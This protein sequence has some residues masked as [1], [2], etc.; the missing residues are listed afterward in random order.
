M[1]ALILY[2]VTSLMLSNTPRAPQP[3]HSIISGDVSAAAV[4][5]ICIFGRPGAGKTSVAESAIAKLQQQSRSS[6]MLSR[7]TTFTIDPVGLDLDVCVPQWMKE[8]FAKGIY[9]TLAERRAF[10]KGCCDYVEE[11]MASA[12]ATRKKAQLRQASCPPS[13]RDCVPQP[14]AD[15][16]QQQQQSQVDGD[17][18]NNWNNTIIFAIVSFSFVNTD[19]RDYYRERFPHTQWV[20]IDTSES[21]ATIR[22]EQRKGHFY[23]GAVNSKTSFNNTDRIGIPQLPSALE[24]APT[25][26][27]TTARTTTTRESRH[28]NHD[29][30]NDDWKFAP[31]DF[32]HIVLD[33]TNSIGDNADQVVEIIRTMAQNHFFGSETKR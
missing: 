20:L 30:D 22:I 10:A 27:T 23:K 18:N 33:G 32:D 6:I 21:E 8:N 26:T 5:M 1:V 12:A 25:T 31:V 4:P 3:T 15:M 2:A 28:N 7:S 9:P 11:S 17:D 19:L 13:S 16:L 29:D 24:D 14:S